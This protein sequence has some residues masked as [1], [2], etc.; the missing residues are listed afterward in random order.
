MCFGG[1]EKKH[2][3]PN[4]IAD[5][6]SSVGV[7][8]L[9]RGTVGGAVCILYVCVAFGTLL[10]KLR[11]LNHRNPTCRLKTCASMGATTSASTEAACASMEG[12]SLASMDVDLLPRTMF[13]TSFHESRVEVL[14]PWKKVVFH[15]HPGSWKS[16]HFRDRQCMLLPWKSHGSSWKHRSLLPSKSKWE[17]STE[18]AGSFYELPG[19][20]MKEGE[21]R[22]FHGWM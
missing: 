11:P 16:T 5:M 15:K 9:R 13:S 17:K 1:R 6:I 2:E 3:R 12:S 4:L 14:P 19:A 18:V 22:L 7:K 20:S 21:K 8:S 10:A